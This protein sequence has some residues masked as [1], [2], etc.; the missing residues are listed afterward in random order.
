VGLGLRQCQRA[1]DDDR[2]CDREGYVC[3]EGLG[4]PGTS[5]P[6][7]CLPAPETVK[8]RDGFV[9]DACRFD[10]QC[11]GGTCADALGAFEV[12]GQSFGGTPTPDG[13]CSGACTEDADC[14]RDGLCVN[15]LPFGNTAGACYLACG[16]ACT[17]P[18]YVC[19]PVM[20]GAGGLG[21][22]IPEA[23][24][25]ERVQEEDAGVPDAGG[26]D[27]GAPDAGE[28]DG[29]A[30]LD[31]GG[32]DA[33]ALDAGELDAGELDGGPGDPDAS[34]GNDAGSAS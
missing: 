17:R 4:F 12:F 24:V 15:L 7:T 29:G 14:G 2:D 16:S 6:S 18:G 8:I 34:D 13:Y 10:L 19:A 31:A 20:V 32:P 30:L 28:A 5:A 3:S 27:A 9:G 26:P 1:C 23:C 33:G 21:I 11:G 22:D 25:P